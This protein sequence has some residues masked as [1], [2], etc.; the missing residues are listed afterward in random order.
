M[1]NKDNTRSV[2]EPY[3]VLAMDLFISLLAS[4]FA[5]L[6]VRWLA[7][8]IPNFSLLALKWAAMSII[9]S[10]AGFLIV[11][12]HKISLVYS[13]I[14]STSKL[15]AA[16]FIKEVILTIFIITDLFVVGSIK[17]RILIILLDCIGGLSGMILI[18]SLIIGIMERSHNSIEFNVNRMGILIYGISDKSTALI[19]RLFSSSHYNP[20]AFITTDRNF[21]GRIIH[22]RKVFACESQE[23]FQN[24]CAT[25][26]GIEGIIFATATDE[27]EQKDKIVQWCSNTGVNT[28]ISP[29]VEVTKHA[30]DT[31]RYQSDTAATIYSN[32]YEPGFIADGMSGFERNIKRAVD[33]FTALILLIIFSPLFL[34]CY[35]AI[36]REDHGP[37]IFKQERIGRFGRPFNIYKFRSMKLDAEAAGPALYSGDEDP[38]LTKVGKFLRQHHLDELP[39]LYNVLRGDMAF[40]GYR[41]ERQFYID[42]I[43]EKDPRY[44]Y[45][46]QIRP[47]VTSYSTLKNGYTD[48]M[49]KMLRRLQFDLYYLKNRSWAFDIK[50]LFQ[51]FI[52][53]VFGKKF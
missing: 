39:Q 11:G 9:A 34:I 10:A 5:L 21:N 42:Q 52:N 33:M 32:A 50:I 8:P 12:S 46:Y 48:S 1:R 19:Q 43:I 18:R 40:I 2:N 30:K 45:L 3:I 22:D 15:A 28:L 41:P 16:I 14:R 4:L 49:E 44:V 27:E 36:K 47:G 24:I 37:A 38:R 20:V 51:T 53:I 13:T 23:E 26:G 35:I 25:L 31:V 6:F 17:A 29:Q 7:N